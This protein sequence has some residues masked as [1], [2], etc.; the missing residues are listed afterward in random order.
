MQTPRSADA[1]P[2]SYEG[3]F[4]FIVQYILLLLLLLIFGD[5][6]GE[7]DLDVDIEAGE[8]WDPIRTLQNTTE[9]WTWTW[10]WDRGGQGICTRLRDLI[11]IL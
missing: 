10:T 11:L 4:L 7:H 1:V 8:K 2:C 5:C 6:G 9:K 3:Y